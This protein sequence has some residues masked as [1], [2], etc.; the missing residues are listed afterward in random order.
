MHQTKTEENE[1]LTLSSSI[2]GDEYHSRTVIPLVRLKKSFFNENQYFLI[3]TNDSL[4]F[5]VIPE[6]LSWTIN[7]QIME[8]F[9]AIP[10]D[11]MPDEDEV[12]S[13]ILRKPWIWKE[14][15]KISLERILA[16][17]K[18]NFMIPFE[19]ICSLT[20]TL[21]KGAY[22][23]LHIVTST[24]KFYMELNWGTGHIVYNCL[25]NWPRNKISLIIE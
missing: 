23:T 9:D 11:Q 25:S 24:K 13:L 22:D 12:I 16:K 15:E 2:D 14:Y 4:F 7:S 6:D 5:A 1:V 21:I 3:I 8:E 20:I 18:E 17:N 19:E 10:I